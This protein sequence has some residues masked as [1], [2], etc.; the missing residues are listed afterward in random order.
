MTTS[1]PTPTIREQARDLLG[2][3]IPTWF[4]DENVV[5]KSAVLKIDGILDLI[6]PLFEAARLEGLLE[7]K[8]IAEDC[9]D[10]QGNLYRVSFHNSIDHSIELTKEQIAATAD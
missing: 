8:Q 7:A 5:P 1:T 2:R 3:N 10:G 4:Y 6:E 9:T